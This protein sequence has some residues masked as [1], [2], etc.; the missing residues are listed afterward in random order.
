MDDLILYNS[1]NK[2]SLLYNK[3][4]SMNNKI[5]KRDFSFIVPHRKRNTKIEFEKMKINIIKK[6]KISIGII[7]YLSLP[8]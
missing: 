6:K 7:N 3:R 5:N 4:P 1:M 8:N 2:F